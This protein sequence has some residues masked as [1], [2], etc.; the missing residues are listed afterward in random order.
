MTQHPVRIAAAAESGLVRL[1]LLEAIVKRTPYVLNIGE[2]LSGLDFDVGEPP[3]AVI[4]VA[5]GFV[6]LYDATDATTADDGVTCLV[7]GNG[8][9]YHIEDSAAL[10]LSAVLGTATV[11]PGSPT[12]GDAWIVGAAATGDFAGHDDDIALSTRRGWVFATPDL[13][14]TVLDESTD[15]NTQFT[16]TGWGTFAPALGDGAV[17]PGALA[18]PGGLVVEA[19]LSTPPGSP[20]AGQWWIVGTSPTGA[21]SGQAGKLAGWDGAAYSFLTPAEGWTVWH[22]V[23]GYQ[24]SYVSGAWVN[25]Q[26]SLLSGVLKGCE[27]SNNALDATN[28]IDIAA[29]RVVDSTGAVIIS[30]PAIS[31][32]LDAAWA[33]GSGNGG[34]D[35]GAIA[36]NWWHVWAILR[37]DTGV[38]DVL[39]SLSATAPTMPTGYDYKAR[40]GSINR[41]AAAI[42]AFTQLGDV[43]KWSTSVT[44]ISTANPGTSAVTASLSV[45][46]GVIVE[47]IVNFSVSATGSVASLGYALMTTLRQADTVPST[48]NFTLEYSDYGGTDV[49]PNTVQTE[50]ETNTSRQVRYRISQSAAAVTAKINTVGWIDRRGKQ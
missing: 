33:V 3:L 41:S 1:T 23:F 50:I 29:G 10:S 24:V 4:A 15:E 48:T 36:D 47:A 28:D 40:L 32:R 27:L 13:G 16:A 14:M 45:P 21:W 38:V 20:V 34:R 31:K 11:A 42:V 6:Y 12:L 9:R 44:D 26:I 2:S 22:K 7:T 35:T 49:G 37:S 25:A 39:F 46:L 8:L 19:T 18:F 5:T 43:F 30:V 17:K